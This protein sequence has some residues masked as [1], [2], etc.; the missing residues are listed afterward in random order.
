MSGLTSYSANTSKKRTR[1]SKPTVASLSR[2]LRIVQKKMIRSSEYKESDVVGTAN[3]STAG[4]FSNLVPITQGLTAN[5]RIGDS[6][7]L[8]SLSI[9]V[10]ADVDTSDAFD[11]CRLIVFHDKTPQG[12]TPSLTDVI[13]STSAPPLGYVNTANK[14]RFRIIYDKLFSLTVNGPATLCD[15]QYRKLPNIVSEYNGNASIPNSGGLFAL[16][17]S[18]SS[19]APN[20]LFGYSFR[21]RYTDN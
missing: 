13:N 7:T 21:V 11:T 18:N 20:V 16:F 10:Y 3:V 6:I 19:V 17:W 12:A 9:Q 8:K 4:A 5:N 14:Q 15:K 1:K 2:E